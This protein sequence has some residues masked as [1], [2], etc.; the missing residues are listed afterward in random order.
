[1]DTKTR[2]L[3]MLSTRD[4]PQNQGRI[5]TEREQ[6]EKD[7][8]GKWR[9]KESRVAIFMS[10]KID[11]EIKPMKRAKEGHYIMIKGLVKEEYITII[12]IYAPDIGAPQ[13]V[14]QMLTN[15]KGKLTVTQKS[16]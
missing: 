15:M 13:Y 7:I 3:Y 1:M 9:T 5:E 11:F 12:N 16:W 10:N 8:S 14:R 6:L 2:S 4:P